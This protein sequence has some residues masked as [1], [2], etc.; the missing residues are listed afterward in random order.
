MSAVDALQRCLAGEH[1]VV[2]GYGVLGG[3]LAGAGVEAE[4]VLAQSSYDAHVARRDDLARRV[5]DLG[6]EP[7]A[8]ESSYAVPG[9]VDDVEAC[10]RLARELESGSATVYAAAVAETVDDLRELVARALLDCA[11]RAREWGEQDDALPGLP[12]R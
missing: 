4:L 12:E 2:Y 1:A 7:V 5:R 6:G 3:F 10:R 9:R 11:L 8:A